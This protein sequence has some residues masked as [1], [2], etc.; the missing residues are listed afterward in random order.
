MT[1]Y[2]RIITTLKGGTADRVPMMLHSFMAAANEAGYTMEEYRS[3]PQKIADAHI[4]F[5]EKY[6]T[7]GILLDIDTCMEASAIGVPTDY[8]EH[9]PARVT[10]PL[11]SDVSTLLDAMKPEKLLHSKRVD[12]NL[13]A[14]R[15]IKRQIGGDLLLRGNCDQ[16]GFSLAMLA[17]GMNDFMAD[18]L[19]EDLEDDLLALIDHATDVHIA[20][21]K[22][23]IQAGADV[24]SFGDSAC[25]PDLIS[26]DMYLKYSFPFHQ[27]IAR[28]LREEGIPVI[29]HIC[30]NLD[31]ILAD[32]CRAGFPA[33]EADYKTNIPQAAGILRDANVV[34]FGPIDP[35][36]LFYF[37]TPEQMCA[38]TQSVLN[39]FQGKQLVIGAG[40]ALP[41]GTPERNI[42]AF[43][44]TVRAYPMPG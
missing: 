32:V 13:K 36:G 39:I 42:R 8:P 28:A 12:I 30:G 11:S 16:A 15:L 18:L 43:T 25:G 2:E 19:D 26:R 33:V 31:R 14:V 41:S 9:E 22:M 21:H 40:C 37:G 23:M 27:K 35:S 44:E 17:Y 5:A 34:M 1:G 29:C 3:D 24:T 38:E 10:G 4:R 7:D 6:S 20:F